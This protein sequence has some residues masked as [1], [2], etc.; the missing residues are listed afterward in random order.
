MQKKY[1]TPRTSLREAIKNASGPVALS[2]RVLLQFVPISYL[3]VLVSNPARLEGSFLQWISVAT[4]GTLATI[5]VLLAFRASLLPIYPNRKSKP[6]LTSVAFVTAGFVRGLFIYL[7]G[8]TFEIMPETEFIFRLWGGPLF[9]YGGIAML[10]IFNSSR[11][12]HESVLSDLAT[13]KVELDELRGGIKERIRSQRQDLI[14]RVQEVLV[15]AI[16]NVQ[17]ELNSQKVSLSNKLREIV[18]TVVRPLSHEIGSYATADESAIKIGKRAK[19]V[20][21]KGEFPRV[22]SAGAMLVPELISFAT[23]SIAVASNALNFPDHVLVTSLLSLACVY[24]GYKLI[25]VSLYR[26]WV[27]VFVAVLITFLAALTV[28]YLTWFA[29][30]LFGFELPEIILYEFILSQVFIGSISFYM[31]YLRTKRNAAEVEMTKVI[32]D[33]AILNSQLRQEVWLNRRRIASVLHGSVQ[34]ALYASAIRLAKVES[35]SA[36]EVKNV[37]ADIAAAISKLESTD[38]AET[39]SG[40]L[41][42]IREVWDGAVE[43]TLPSM[44]ADLVAKLDANPVASSCASEVVREAVSNAV[45]HGKAEHVVIEVEQTVPHLLGITVTN[46]GQPLPAEV[47]AG[48]GSSILNEVAFTWQLENRGGYTVLGAAIAI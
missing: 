15:P 44:G 8:S 25:Q 1:L 20:I 28:S 6:L 35:P 27:P 39:F 22:V 14:R 23:A 5:L 38:G 32:S 11:L 48:Y 26:F 30:G 3:L 18:E 40:V 16:E 12:R 9:V 41:E 36:Q 43:V 47:E 29:L 2:N 31:Q 45:K 24:F 21:S 7:V 13:E 19:R 34:A 37:Q 17:S 4:I 10:A 46:D 42:Q 33:L